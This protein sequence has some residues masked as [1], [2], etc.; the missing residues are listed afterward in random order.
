MQCLNVFITL[1]S[2]LLICKAGIII[3][4]SWHLK[5]LAWQ[6]LRNKLVC[7]KAEERWSLNLGHCSGVSEKWRILI[8]R[9]LPCAL[10]CQSKVSRVMLLPASLL[11]HQVL[12]LEVLGRSLDAS[13]MGV[14]DGLFGTGPQE[15]DGESSKCTP[16]YLGSSILAFWHA[17]K[18]ELP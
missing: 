15:I 4:V 16:H 3:L 12:H 18:G 10:K 9:Y 2:L 1:C 8:I 13:V 5:W 11:W 7:L 6:Y 14:A 17:S